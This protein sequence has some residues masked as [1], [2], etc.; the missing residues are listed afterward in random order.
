MISSG[1]WRNTQDGIKIVEF[2]CR[3]NW[4]SPTEDNALFKIGKF[5][6][7]AGFVFIAVFVFF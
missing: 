5:V 2:F 3:F 1:N 4:V 6:F 7:K